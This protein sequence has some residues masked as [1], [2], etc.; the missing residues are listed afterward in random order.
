MEAIIMPSLGQTSDEAYIQEWYFKEGD[1]VEMGDPLLSVET[2]KALL[3]VECV[4]DGVLLKIVTPAD[5]S[6]T[7]GTIIAYIGEEGEEA[8]E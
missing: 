7:A 5:A 4:A 1:T 8:P 6:V 3:D 2:D